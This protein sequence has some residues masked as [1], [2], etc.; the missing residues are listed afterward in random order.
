MFCFIDLRKGI[1]SAVLCFI[2]AWF[3]SDFDFLNGGDPFTVLKF[4]FDDEL[5]YCENPRSD[6]LK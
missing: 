3:D 4:D 5:L 2:L 6:E 1:E